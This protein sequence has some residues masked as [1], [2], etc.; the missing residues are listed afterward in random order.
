[1]QSIRILVSEVHASCG[2]DKE[3]WRQWDQLELPDPGSGNRAGHKETECRMQRGGISCNGH[4]FGRGEGSVQEILPISKLELLV[5]SPSELETE[6][7]RFEA[8]NMSFL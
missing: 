3:R 1:M 2:V 8:K 5:V 7:S 4:W 6:R